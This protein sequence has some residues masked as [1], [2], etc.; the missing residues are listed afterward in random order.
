MWNQSRSEFVCLLLLIRIF[1]LP[2]PCQKELRG[3]ENAEIDNEFCVR[4]QY[5]AGAESDKFFSGNQPHQFGAEVLL[6]QIDAAGHLRRF[7][8]NEFYNL[9]FVHIIIVREIIS[10][11]TS[12]VDMEEMR[13]V[14]KICIRK[15]GRKARNFLIS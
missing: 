7:Y 8:R 14:H 9:Y 6:L 5:F 13:N 11:A 2:T 3:E 12:S 10:K 4:L 1:Y 15:P